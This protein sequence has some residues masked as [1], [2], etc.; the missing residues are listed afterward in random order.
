[1]QRHAVH[2]LSYKPFKCDVCQREFSRRDHAIKHIQ[3]VHRVV[4]PDRAL[5]NVMQLQLHRGGVQADMEEDPDQDQDPDPDA[6]IEPL[7]LQVEQSANARHVTNVNVQ[8]TIVQDENLDL[9][10]PPTS[11]DAPLNPLPHPLCSSSRPRS[12]GLSFAVSRSLL[13]NDCVTDADVDVDVDVNTH[14]TWSSTGVCSATVAYRKCN[15]ELDCASN[16]TI[17]DD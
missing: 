4:P 16:D 9:A 10:S 8:D 12:H 13:S 17:S 2:H 1:M 15:E 7:D 5:I 3:T 11:P 6:K 14:A